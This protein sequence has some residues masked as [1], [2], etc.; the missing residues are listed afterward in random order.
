MA[1]TDPVVAIIAT[2]KIFMPRVTE[3]DENNKTKT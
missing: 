1:M 2:Y 3:K